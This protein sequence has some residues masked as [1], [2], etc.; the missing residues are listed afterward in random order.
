M[1]A[2][3][4]VARATLHPAASL[5]ELLEQGC[6]ADPRL[7]ADDQDP[8]ASRPDAGQELA[9]SLPL[10]APT[11]QAPPRGDFGRRPS[12]LTLNIRPSCH[13]L[14]PWL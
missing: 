9:E 3:T 10:A 14:E 2:C 11:A 6:L 13:S 4:P 7:A 1:S 5:D 12:R 8:A